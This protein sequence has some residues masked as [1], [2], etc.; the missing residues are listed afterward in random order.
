M[1]FYNHFGQEN[2]MDYDTAIRPKAAIDH[3]N[4]LL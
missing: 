2:G 3:L 1:S 4:K